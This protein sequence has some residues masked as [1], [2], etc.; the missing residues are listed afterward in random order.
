MNPVGSIMPQAKSPKIAA[1]LKHGPAVAEFETGSQNRAAFN[2]PRVRLSPPARSTLPVLDRA[3]NYGCRH[4]GRPSP[5]G[6]Q[7]AHRHGRSPARCTSIP[8]E[9]PSG[10]DGPGYSS[11]LRAAGRGADQPGTSLRT[12]PT[13][14]AQT[15]PSPTDG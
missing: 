11:L 10:G 12:A 6:A 14:I 3:R 4:I 7:K 13:T 8:G 5:P 15:R 2:T 9:R 1:R